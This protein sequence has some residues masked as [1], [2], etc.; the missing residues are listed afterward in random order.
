ML[1]VQFTYTE[2][3]KSKNSLDEHKRKNEILTHNKRLN[4]LYPVNTKKSDR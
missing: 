4:E 3:G 2:N 1:P